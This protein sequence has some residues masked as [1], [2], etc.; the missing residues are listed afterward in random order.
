MFK[1][2][3]SK[4]E[5]ITLFNA[6]ALGHCSALDVLPSVLQQIYYFPDGRDFNYAVNIEGNSFC[7]QGWTLN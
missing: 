3:I 5:S 2:S 6:L 1:L 4:I 7:R